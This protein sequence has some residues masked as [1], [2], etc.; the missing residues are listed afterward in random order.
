[1]SV[2]FL[3]EDPLNCPV[4]A[5]NFE[6]VNLI[7]SNEIKYPSDVEISSVASMNTTS[8]V[9]TLKNSN[10][11]MKWQVWISATGLDGMKSGVSDIFNIKINLFNPPL[12]K[13]IEAPEFKFTE[14]SGT[15]A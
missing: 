13:K 4:K 8:G 14:K 7:E 1:M 15:L 5:Y 6:K 11:A 9:F 3:S 10:E 12:T 2:A